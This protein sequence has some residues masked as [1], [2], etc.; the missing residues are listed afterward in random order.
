MLRGIVRLVAEAGRYRRLLVMIDECQRVWELKSTTSKNI[1]IGF[2]TWYDSSHKNL[3]LVLSFRCGYEKYVY[4]LISQD[5]Q[6]R[7]DPPNIS[8]PLLTR[9]NATQFVQDLL[10][11]FRSDCAPSPWF[12]FP[13][14]MVNAVVDYMTKNGGVSP[15]LLMHAFNALLDEADY[16]IETN[17]KFTLSIE[18]AIDLV[19]RVMKTLPEE[20]EEYSTAS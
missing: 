13:E 2:Q 12:P 14:S 10:D 11:A 5:L 9:D 4:H 1:D 18:E 15:R 17:S 3:A 8:L 20:D 19:K 16:Q 6:V 7:A